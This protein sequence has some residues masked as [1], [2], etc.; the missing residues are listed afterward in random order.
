MVYGASEGKRRGSVPEFFWSK[1]MN[2]GGRRDCRC[3]TEP[4]PSS[5]VFSHVFVSGAEEERV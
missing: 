1:R 3:R 4:N 5:P 2:L